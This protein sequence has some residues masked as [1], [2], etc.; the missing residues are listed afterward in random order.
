MTLESFQTLHQN[1]Q[2][3]RFRNRSANKNDDIQTESLGTDFRTFSVD[4]QEAFLTLEHFQTL[5]QYPQ[6]W[7]FRNRSAKER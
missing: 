6:E 3:W 1:P 7:R 2:E 4:G 5:H